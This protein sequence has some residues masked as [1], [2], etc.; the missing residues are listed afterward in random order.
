MKRKEFNK[1]YYGAVLNIFK[2]LKEE[3]LFNLRVRFIKQISLAID[4]D[5]RLLV[6]D[7]CSLSEG[8]I[9]SFKINGEVIITDFPKFRDY[10]YAVMKKSVNDVKDPI[11]NLIQ[12]YFYDKIRITL[13]NNKPILTIDSKKGTFEIYK[14]KIL[15][16][17][18]E[19]I[20]TRKVSDEE[21]VTHILGDIRRKIL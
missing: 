12:M 1:K 8:R 13:N 4:T 19:V 5:E 14:D 2:A 6:A 15:V 18:D 17:V 20:C 16:Q 21:L 9:F 11:V 10:V 3:R 7:R